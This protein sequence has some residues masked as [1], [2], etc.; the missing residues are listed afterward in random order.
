MYGDAF[1]YVPVND[2]TNYDLAYT[3]WFFTSANPNDG[4]TQKRI[5]AGLHPENYDD[6]DTCYLKTEGT[7][8]HKPRPFAEALSFTECQPF[9]KNACCEEA[10]VENS[11]VINNLYG[12]EY[13]WDR[14]GAVKRMSSECER[15]FVQENCFYECDPNPGLFRKYSPQNVTAN[16]DLD[17]YNWELYKMPIKGDYC[18]A[19][20]D[21]CRLDY[22][23]GNGNFFE[24][25]KIFSDDPVPVESGLSGGAIAGIVIGS[26]VLAAT[27][28]FLGVLIRNERMGH[29]VFQRMSSDDSRPLSKPLSQPQVPAA[30]QNDVT[31]I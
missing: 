25:K 3:M 9:R 14:C 15:F 27:L 6:T 11:S 29:P 31:T 28:C 7:T 16:P 18:D 10:T 24:C 2:T 17:D 26:I 22:F 5:Q 30:G 12:P 4:T 23:C 13:R 1:K 20:Y 21:A 8:L 19:W